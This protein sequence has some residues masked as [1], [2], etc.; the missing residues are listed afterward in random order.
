MEEQKLAADINRKVGY[1]RARRDMLSWARSKRRFI[2][3]I[4]NWFNV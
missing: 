2:R 1:H 3:Y 4:F